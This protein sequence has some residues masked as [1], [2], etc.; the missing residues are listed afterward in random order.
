LCYSDA[1]LNG[2]AIHKDLALPYS[3]NHD[4]HHP[5]KYQNQ[6]NCI[7]ISIGSFLKNLHPN[8]S[9]QHPDFIKTYCMINSDAIIPTFHQLSSVSAEHTRPH[10]LI[11]IFI[12]IAHFIV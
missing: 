4:V 12:R 11:P 1:H 9:F 10:S 3:S 6:N 5:N 7:D 8:P 2:Y